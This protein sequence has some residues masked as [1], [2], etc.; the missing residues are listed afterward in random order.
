EE[1]RGRGLLLGLKLGEKRTAKELQA[2]LLKKH[3]LAGT[4]MDAQVL[5]LMPP[6][7][8]TRSE[9]DLLVE[10]IKTL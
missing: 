10:A 8:L 1:V 9:A 5:R 6:L 2:A 4:S 3:I 7:V